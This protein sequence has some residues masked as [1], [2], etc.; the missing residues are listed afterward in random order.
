MKRADILSAVALIA[1]A[2]PAPVWASEA[3][4]G[5]EGKSSLP[6]LD[7]ALYP[8]LLFWLIVVFF[9]FFLY[10][11]FVGAPGVRKAR[12]KRTGMISTDLKTAQ[13][14]SEEAKKVVEAYEASLAEARQKA[15]ATVNAILVQ[16]ERE[17]YERS[18][19]LRD[20]L[21][22]R[23]RVAEANI[24]EAQQKAMEDAPK[25][26]ND[27]VQDLFAKVLQVNLSGASKAGAK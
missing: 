26:V 12:D 27:L 8:G 22:H 5:G 2:V 24:A 23:T 25:H 16:A 13:A 19:K 1:L 4:H 17:A 7:V 11:R 9:L 21:D 18:D 6:Q 20:E 15:N 14:A 10:V 3:A